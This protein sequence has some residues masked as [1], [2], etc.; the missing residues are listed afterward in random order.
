MHENRLMDQQFLVQKQRRRN[1]RQSP[2]GKPSL[3]HTF[4]QFVSLTHLPLNLWLCDAHVRASTVTGPIPRVQ[5]KL[6]LRL[7]I[8]LFHVLMHDTY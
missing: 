1:P 7:Y 5:K 3:W 4:S 2:P 6:G 8:A